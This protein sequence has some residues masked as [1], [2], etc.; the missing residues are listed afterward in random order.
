M[1]GNKFEISNFICPECRNKF[2]LPRQKSK[3]RSKGHIK[4]LYCPFCKKVVKTMEI[5]PD[6][7]IEMYDGSVFY[8]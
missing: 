2:P 5:R 7:Y 4:D 6:D 1:T 3:R 8:K